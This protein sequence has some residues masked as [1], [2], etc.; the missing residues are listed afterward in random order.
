MGSAK[1]FSDFFR[2]VNSL[3]ARI[4]NKQMGRR[5]QVVM[6]RFKSPRIECD[7]S[8]LRVMRY[9]DCNPF[10]A[11][12]V[13]CPS[14][15]EWSSYNYYALGEP[16]KLIT[17]APSYLALG[18]TPEDRQASYREL[19]NEL[20]SYSEIKKEDYSKVPFIGNP[21]W[22]IE[23]VKKLKEV[24]ASRWKKWKEKFK[25]RFGP[26]SNNLAKASTNQ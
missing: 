7:Q 5:G 23:Q 15:N 25:E 1:D 2:T 21:D 26:P 11:G 10:R 14:E 18:A 6:D 4:Y 16:D 24:R 19:V 20:C 8:M 9:I 3:F 17:P 22:V 13:Q 12:K